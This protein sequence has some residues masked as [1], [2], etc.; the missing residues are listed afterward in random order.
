MGGERSWHLRFFAWDSHTPR[1]CDTRAAHASWDG[2]RHNNSIADTSAITE[3]FSVQG[4]GALRPAP[5]RVRATAG[6]G[7]DEAPQPDGA[8]S[9]VDEVAEFREDDVLPDSLEDSIS[10]AAT[11]R[12]GA[13]VTPRLRQRP[14]P[15]L[16]DPL[17]RLAAPRRRARR[18]FAQVARAASWRSWSP[19]SGTPSAARCSRT[20]ETSSGGGDSR[21]DSSTTC[22]KRCRDAGRVCC[23]RTWA[24]RRCWQTSGRTACLTCRP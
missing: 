22:C 21:V 6:E 12:R 7:A 5:R 14:L 19:S 24:S 11:V 9:A 4:T 10:Q 3:R 18:P 23:T 16:P 2:F 8:S 20:R 13:P 17:L 1:R 15:S